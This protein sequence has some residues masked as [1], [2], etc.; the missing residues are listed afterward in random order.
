MFCPRPQ[1]RAGRRALSGELFLLL[2]CCIAV[3]LLCRP[4]ALAADT[5]ATPGPFRID[6]VRT[7]DLPWKVEARSLSYDQ[8]N[9][10]VEAEGQ[11]RLS[12]ADRLILA[13]RAAL[14]MKSRKAELWGNVSLQYGRDWLKGQH[15]LWNLDSETGWLD[16]GVMY[17]A[18][19]NFFVQGSSIAKT[20]EK[21]FELQEGYLTSC[22][23]AD[24]DWKIQYRNMKI[25]ADGV[26]WARDVSMW[27]RSFPVMFMPVIG[28]PVEKKRQSGFLLPYAGYSSD[29]GFEFEQPYYWAI[30]DDMDATL[31]GRYLSERGFMSGLEFRI[32]NPTWGTGVWAANYLHDQSDKVVPAEDRFWLRARHNMELPWKIE[33]KIDLDIV[34][35]RTFLPEFTTG[36]TSVSQAEILFRDRFGRG[37]LFDSTASVRESTLYLEKRKESELLSMDLRYFQPLEDRFD[38]STPQKLPGFSYTIIPQGLAGT[39]FYYTLDSSAVNWWRREGDSE[40]RL[41]LHP[42]IYYPMHWGNYL[43]VEPS[44]GFRST[45]YVVEWDN[46]DYDNLNHRAVSDA[47]VAM[48]SRLNRVYPINLWGAVALEHS[49]RPEVSYEYAAQSTLGHVPLIDRLDDNRAR[50]GIRYGF[51]T[52]LTAKE[53]TTD[54]QGNQVSTFREWVRLKA[55]QFYNAEKPEVDDPLF[56]TEVLKTGFSPVGIRLDLSPLRWATFS[57]D[58]DFD[59]QST[60]QGDAHDV[61]MMVTS[62]R[63]HFLTIDYQKRSDLDV[64]E[65][66]TSLFLKTWKNI[67]LNTYQDYSISDG[68][69]FRHGYG[70]R[71]YSGCWGIGVGFEREGEDN[72]FLISLDLLGIGTFG[73]MPAIGK[74][75]FSEPYPEFQRPEAYKLVN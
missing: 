12:S 19:N 38:N 18:E 25:D 61:S 69:L 66:I 68:E 39:P 7:G 20:G 50:N 13:D 56:K 30:R 72:R 37:I 58:A 67:Y 36:S 22:N 21:T 33:A 55:F 29:N 70:L 75:F 1:V 46:K 57:Y 11:V 41:D 60:G 6:N 44:V 26:A 10:T 59:L 63:G 34:S 53:V 2:V 40:Q 9:Q 23:P 28:V 52:F 14:D 71:Y 65:V 74:T 32:N 35:D 48:S 16:S 49:I 24:P 42:R 4:C 73:T 45:S 54:A 15:L 64:N 43:D 51:S 47:Q 62:G 17:F 5:E 31:Y 27:A 8:E 3:V